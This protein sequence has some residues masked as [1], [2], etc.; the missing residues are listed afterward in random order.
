MYI[1][2]IRVHISLINVTY[3]QNVYLQKKI[4]LPAWIGPFHRDCRRLHILQLQCYIRVELLRWNRCQSVRINFGA[5]NVPAIRPGL[6]SFHERGATIIAGQG[7]AISIVRTK[8]RTTSFVKRNLP[9]GNGN[10]DVDKYARKNVQRQGIVPAERKL[11][12]I[13]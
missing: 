8:R 1:A 7:R 11:F 13:G 12:T 3:L 2:K 4:L 9:R 6:F 5:V 10:V